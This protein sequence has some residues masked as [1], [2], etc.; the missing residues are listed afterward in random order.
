MNRTVSLWLHRA[1]AVVVPVALLA[2]WAV[3]SAN[4]GDFYFPPLADILV[5]FRETWLFAQFGSDVVPSVARALAGFFIAVVLGVA[6]GVTLGLMPRVRRA[7]S[8][9]IEFVRA[10]PPPAFI[11]IALLVIGVGD[12]MKV[13]VI[14]FVCVWPILLNAVAG[15][16]SVEPVRL[17]TAASYGLGRRARLR[18]I[19]LPSIGPQVFAGMRTSLSVAL[20]L[21]V[22]TE[23]VASTDGVGYFILSAQRT[24]AL[25]DMW[26]GIILLGVLG[27]TLNLLLTLAERWVLRWYLDSR[28]LERAGS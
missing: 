20:I 18:W 27:F 4:A 14:A 28:A 5:A 15:T 12:T 21:M 22:I 13:S 9:I 6:G 2:A 26:A 8:P 23:M 3:W 24:F 7:V 1:L 25:T 11:P 10:I 19:V 17:E 16:T